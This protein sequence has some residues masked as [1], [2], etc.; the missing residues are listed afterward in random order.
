MVTMCNLTTDIK[1]MNEM[2]AKYM[3]KAKHLT[4][5]YD[6]KLALEEKEESEMLKNG[7]E[8]EQQM[9]EKKMRAF[10]EKQFL[11]WRDIIDNYNQRRKD[12]LI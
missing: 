3:V 2:C 12:T 6:M 8:K 11:R 10:N 4:P 5:V 9:R 1:M 7:V